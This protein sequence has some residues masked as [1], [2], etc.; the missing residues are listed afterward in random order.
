MSDKQW[1]SKEVRSHLA[2]VRKHFGVS[3][4]LRMTALEIVHL[5]EAYDE[6]HP[7]TQAQ[8]NVVQ[9]HMAAAIAKRSQF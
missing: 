5:L 1:G 9:V 7:I 3:S 2:K 4:T 8:A 6:V